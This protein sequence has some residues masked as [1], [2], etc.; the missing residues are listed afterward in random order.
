MTT[1]VTLP[2]DVTFDVSRDVYRVN[3]TATSARDVDLHDVR[4]EIRTVAGE[5]GIAAW[6]ALV[7]PNAPD[8]ASSSVA[9]PGGAVEAA[10][11]GR[12]FVDLK[13]SYG[14]PWVQS[15]M[16][17][18]TPRPD[19]VL[20]LTGPVGDANPSLLSSSNSDGGG[21]VTLAEVAGAAAAAK[22]GQPTYVASFRITAAGS[23]LVTAS[24]SGV[25][26]GLLGGGSS[27]TATVVIAPGPISALTTSA[28]GAGLSTATAGDIATVYVAPRDAFGNPCALYDA[29]GNR[30]ER[31]LE[32]AA[33]S[34][35]FCV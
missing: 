22:A 25:S 18:G 24:A 7:Y 26:F 32:L 29:A 12:V 31:R 4:L 27:S 11:L 23:Y 34:V 16:P 10:T 20:Q 17:F 33:A 5:I 6:K 13:D 2:A 19:V 21:G 9:P 28:S 30:V 15:L 14:N 1:S 8:A 3:Y 35:G